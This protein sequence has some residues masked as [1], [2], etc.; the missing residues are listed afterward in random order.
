MPAARDKM[1]MVYLEKKEFLRNAGLSLRFRPR[2]ILSR[3]Y[4][5]R[6]DISFVLSIITDIHIFKHLDTLY[7]NYVLLLYIALYFYRLEKFFV[8]SF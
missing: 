5:I 1:L 3:N 2:S 4:K 6:K 7:K 8:V